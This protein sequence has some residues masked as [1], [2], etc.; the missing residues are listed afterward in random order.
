TA[1][2]TGLENR[3]TIFSDREILRRVSTEFV[4]VATD[5]W[6]LRRQKDP[7]GELLRALNA[8]GLKKG[9]DSGF[10]GMYCLAADG[11]FLAYANPGGSVQTVH[12]M[13]NIA[14]KEWL[15]L[16]ENSRAPG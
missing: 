10:Q 8:Q 9:P 3:R 1:C 2:N 14:R 4:P 5:D 11:K 16:P 6:Y 7:E 12:D 13:M 15:S